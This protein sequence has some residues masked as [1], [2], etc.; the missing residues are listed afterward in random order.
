MPLPTSQSGP[1]ES[2]LDLALDLQ[3]AWNHSSDEIWGR[4]DPG[5]WALTHNP[6]FVLQT[7]SH[8]K[9]EAICSDPAFEERLQLTIRNRRNIYE[10]PTW[11]GT[12]YPNSPLTSAAY[13]SMEYALSEALPIYSGGLGNV[14]GDQL[15]S[16]SDLGVPVTAIGLLYQ[17]GYFRQIIDSD[18]SQRALYPYNDPTQLPITPVRNEAGEWVRVTVRLPA[19][20]LT[21]RAWHARVGRVRLY[22]LD[23]NDP[24][25]SPA[26]RGIT[27]ELYGTG[28]ELRLQQEIALGIGGWRLLEAVGLAPEVCHLNEGHAA[29]AVLER[30][31]RYSAASGLP[32]DAA[33]MITRAGNLF[34]THTPVPAGFD[35]FPPDMIRHYFWRY[36]PEKLGIPIDAMLA[37][38]QNGG[39]EFNM[40]NLAI[41]GSGYVNGVSQ[42]HGQVSRT[43]FQSL[44]PRW[45]KEE[46]PI[47]HVTNGVHVPTWDSQEADELW[48]TVCGRGRWRGTLQNLTNCFRTATDE[49]IWGM[50]GRVRAGLVHDVRH[51]CSREGEPP[52]ATH[53]ILDP[54]VLTLGFAR[55]F[56]TYKRPNLLL[57]DPERLIR[58]LTNPTH[59]VQLVVAGK[60]HPND[61]PGQALLREWIHFMQRP[62]VHGRA[63]FLGD[64]DLD[65][66]QELVKGVD[67]WINTPR[68]PWE[69][70]GTS[71]MKILVNG[72]LNLSEL[73]GWWAEAY[74]P[75]VGWCLG[76]GNEHFDDPGWDGAEANHLYHLLENEI[77]PLFYDRDWNGIPA[78]WV[79][80]IRESMA[81]LTPQF[82]SNRSVREYTE[83]YYLKAAAAYRKRADNGGALGL[84]LLRWR[85]ALDDGWNQ[86]H[87][88]KHEVLSTPTGHQFRLHIHL[89]ELPADS[90]R[91]EIYADPDSPGQPPFRQTMQPCQE[92]PGVT[93]GYC[94][95][96]EVP[97]SRPADHYTPRVIPHHRDAVVPLE[98]SHIAWLV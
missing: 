29:F 69:A 95:V 97:N 33:L 57:R 90:V 61:G 19:G 14:A 66:A 17:R 22:L 96:A 67:V 30:A 73:D 35:R 91:V 87:V 13:F 46:V 52:G 18:G 4:I 54:N 51:R 21:L 8:R 16:A 83:N 82:S 63:V 98:A 23:S 74:A 76:D 38:G 60:A 85:Q 25:N 62:E 75:E 37:L 89:D 55:R 93:G 6:W 20:P 40:A 10:S 3:W 70:C 50:R 48:T 36:A 58:I 28:V 42:L 86:I 84:D 15:K 56:A 31:A 45:P 27:S 92:L 49:Q 41:R 81:R 26:A 7:A 34:T 2:L 77:A 32:F 1:A 59:P 71:G 94:F 65:L 5:L 47:H 79:A 11:F 43:L 64:Y 80:K 72:G 12:T 24:A 78:G 39:D 88:A 9:L 44:F 53:H 68:R